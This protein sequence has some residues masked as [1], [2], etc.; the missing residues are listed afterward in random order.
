MENTVNQRV[1]QL[2]SK[3]GISQNDFANKID[4]SLM[5][6]SRWENGVHEVPRKAIYRICAE[7]G[8]SEDWLTDGIGELT[9]SLP[10]TNENINP[11][12]DALVEQLTDEIK[13]LRESLKMALQSRANFPKENV[14][15]G[16]FAPKYVA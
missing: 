3:L 13:F 10:A 16:S 9:I 15:V 1:K 2:R 5:T 7:F 8:V 11:W 6:V 4:T 14:L 12:K